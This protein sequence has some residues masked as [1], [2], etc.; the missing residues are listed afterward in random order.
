MAYPQASG[1]TPK[2]L[3]IAQRIRPQPIRPQPVKTP[4]EKQLPESA[5]VQTGDPAKAGKTER[6]Y[7]TYTV[8]GETKRYV[9]IKRTYDSKGR[10]KEIIRYRAF[11]RGDNKQVFMSQRRIFKGGKR[12]VTNEIWI[13][14]K[15]LDLKTSRTI[16]RT[17]GTQEEYHA[18]TATDI[19]AQEIRTRYAASR[20]PSVTTGVPYWPVGKGYPGAVAMPHS[21]Y[22]G[23]YG[24]KP[25]SKEVVDESFTISLPPLTKKKKSELPMISQAAFLTSLEEPYATP[26]KYTSTAGVPLISKGKVIPE[27]Q[28]TGP[29]L[30]R[31]DKTKATTEP[32][33]SEIPKREVPTDPSKLWEF[34]TTEA[35]KLLHTSAH[36]EPSMV[37]PWI[38]VGA[39]VGAIEGASELAG[40]VV[41]F[42]VGMVTTPG[43]TTVKTVGGFAEAFAD[44][45]GKLTEIQQWGLKKG[46]TWG[47][48]YPLTYFYTQAKL[49]QVGV[50]KVK[51]ASDIYTMATTESYP[52]RPAKV[53]AVGKSVKTKQYLADLSDTLK[54]RELS[55]KIPAPIEK[56][57]RETPGAALK[58]SRVPELLLG[59]KPARYATAKSLTG[60]DWDIYVKSVETQRKTMIGGEKVD[61]VPPSRSKPFPTTDVG[62]IK[63]QTPSY[64]Y[65]RKFEML[66]EPEEMG[67]FAFA[68][69]ATAYAE[70]TTKTT[71]VKTEVTL[72]VWKTVYPDA[73]PTKFYL[74]KDYLDASQKAYGKVGA[75]DLIKPEILSQYDVTPKVSST[76]QRIIEFQRKP[77]APGEKPGPVLQVGADIKLPKLSGGY[78]P[79][80][81]SLTAAE[82][83]AGKEYPYQS[84]TAKASVGGYPITKT[85]PSYKIMKPTKEIPYAP[86]VTTETFYSTPGVLRKPGYKPPVQP[87]GGYDIVP[88]KI[89][90]LTPPYKSTKEEPPYTPITTTPGAPPPGPP[91][92]P[93]IDIPTTSTTYRIPKEKAKPKRKRDITKFKLSTGTDKLK[94]IYSLLDVFEIEATT[95]RE[96]RHPVGPKAV[97]AFDASLATATDFDRMFFPGL[98]KPKK[99]KKKK[100][101]TAWSLF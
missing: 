100:K 59:E 28:E 52:L 57:L 35:Q 44:P 46:A 16:D 19:K 21:E 89:P 41:E 71:G 53:W 14:D 61:I 63:V 49:T 11:G 85:E 47:P 99:G 58:G 62:G 6:E 15:N 4:V 29:Y 5:P 48:A 8:G 43:A 17:T 84:Y 25:T 92:I 93:L 26:G 72:D 83:P 69:E 20:K 68:K 60:R 73:P 91:D 101:K 38:A 55:K 1:T 97:K 96:A 10:V 13:Y 94:P 18:P 50:A 27:P 23:V 86:T 82:Y 30:E 79:A 12:W 54:G 75:T 33:I 22:Y 65:G 42:G 37:L 70:K 31:F 76:G 95:G 80:E 7:K 36:K 88:I 24:Q 40:T 9:A 64:Y 81:L 74:W 77:T 66:L 3:P 90:V 45:V 34:G 2:P 98:K 87:S 67:R 39:G 78:A 51:T 56:Y 32:L